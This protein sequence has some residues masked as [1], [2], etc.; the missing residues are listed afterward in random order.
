MNKLIF[1]IAVLSIALTSCQKDPIPNP[2]GTFPECIELSGTL[3]TPLTLTNHVTDPAVPDYCISGNYFVE[4][5]LVVEPGVFIV[6]KDDSKIH[7][8]NNGS[9]NCVGTATENIK[10]IG[11]DSIS[12]GQWANI[13]FSTTS[14]DNQL[15]HTNIYGG[16][17]G[18]TYDAM[19]LVG[20]QGAAFIDN[21]GIYLSSTNGIKAETVDS[22]IIGISN[23]DFTLNG[24]YPINVHPIHV[25]SIASSISGINNTHDLIEVRSSQLQ[26][27]ATWNDAFFPYHVNLVLGVNS[28]LTVL[29]GTAFHFA[30]GARL[31][32]TGN[33]SLSC[34]GTP[35]NR[36][37]FRGD[38]N[39][40]T[41]GSWEGV[42]LLSN[43][44]VNEFEYCD[45]SYG[46]GDNNYLGMLTLWSGSDASVGNSSFF[47]SQQWAIYQAGG[48]NNLTDNGNNTH[49][50]NGEPGLINP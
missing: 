30:S 37:T 46:G 13:H 9:F 7:V 28:N 38:S 15:I 49:G 6:M 18:S 22:D 45:F 50:D 31:Q 11:E 27:D 16:G 23:C 21:C 29:P 14:P 41:P 24:L 33:G 25:A 3:S 44:N 19:V 48:V 34:I 2:D 42:V 4:A 43:T 5:D 47:H 20:Y 12:S 39:P 8:R 35:N 36:I 17:N 10:I 1:S 32:V 40:A 26:N